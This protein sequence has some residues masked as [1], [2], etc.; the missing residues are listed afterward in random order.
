MKTRHLVF[1]FIP[2]IIIGGVAL[3]VR[4]L[5]YEPL[6]PEVVPEEDQ[7]KEFQVPLFPKDPILG[8]KRAPITIVAFEDFGCDGCKLQSDIFEQLL[9][10]YPGK[11]K[12]VWKGLPITR[13][14]YQSRE[15]HVYGYCANEQE[16][17][18]EFAK[19]AFVNNYNLSLD[20][21]I[22]IVEQL[23]IDQ[24]KFDACVASPDP[25]AFIKKNEGVATALGI[26]S[27]PTFF[28][29]NKQVEGPSTK[30][31]WV[32]LLGLYAEDNR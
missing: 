32:T 30:E 18:A 28:I 14:P 13:F 15:V 31:G 10:E 26:Q 23:N 4:V 17:F 21:V 24:K 5:Q 6:Y 11:I 22:S 1:I 9:S 16:K 29:N 12:I 19:L 2:A 3:F 7:K 27:V 8:D 25:E 20:I